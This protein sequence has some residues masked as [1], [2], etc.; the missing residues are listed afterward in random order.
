MTYKTRTT[1]SLITLASFTYLLSGCGG[2]L[3]EEGDVVASFSVTC[4]Q[5]VCSVDARASVS[6][7]DTLS[8]LSCDMGDDSLPIDLLSLETI[9]DYTYAAPGSYEITCN[10]ENSDGRS[11]SDTS[12]VV[13]D[14]LLVNAGPDQTVIEGSTVTLDGSQSED[15]SFASTGNEINRYQWE[16]VDV[17][18]AGT[19]FTIINPAS[20]NPTFVAPSN[21]LSTTF[22]LR[23][24]VS[25]DDG[26]SF[27]AAS[28][29]VD[30]TVIPSGNGG[31]DGVSDLP[32]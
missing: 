28:D 2:S 25:I 19:N 23:L 20:A 5:L 27:S 15:T 22:R 18:P 8:V 21:P 13:V 32:Q 24:R 29:V 4:E 17:T 9:F 11:A 10:A 26:V 6:R 7:S 30:I 12:T 1:S 31:G 3:V 16:L 14:G